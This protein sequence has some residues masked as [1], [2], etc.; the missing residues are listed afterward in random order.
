MATSK[1][2]KPQRR[3]AAP[4]ARKDEDV[5]IRVTALQ[6]ARLVAQ[7]S[8]AGMGVSTWLLMLGLREAEKAETG[9]SP[10]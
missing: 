4:K 10:A 3:Q 2:P 6:K 5:R 9:R 8:R 7:A 1:G